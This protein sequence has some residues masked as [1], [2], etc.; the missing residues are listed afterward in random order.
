M[1]NKKTTIDTRINNV[2]SSVQGLTLR[3]NPYSAR[4]KLTLPQEDI[5]GLYRLVCTV[6]TQAKAV[7]ALV[8]DANTSVNPSVGDVCSLRKQIKKLTEITFSLRATIDNLTKST[9]SS[10]FRHLTSLGNQCAAV[11]TRNSSIKELISHFKSPIKDII[12]EILESTNNK[13]VL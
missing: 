6:T 8:N 1:P 3:D 11:A 10:I 12:Q 2:A 9:E 13:D 5:R 7:K 4:N